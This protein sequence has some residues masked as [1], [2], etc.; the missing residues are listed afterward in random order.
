M[1]QAIVESYSR[2]K[3]LKLV[4][5]E[6]GMPF[7]SVYLVLRK[8]GVSV[9]GDKSRYGSETDRLAAGAEREFMSLV[10]D[11][12]NMNEVQFQSKIDFDVHGVTVDVKSSR[13]HQGTRM[14]LI[15]H[16]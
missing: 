16:F 6:V 1:Q 3:N 11:A 2:L 9:T 14:A 12:K 4:G 15:E 13:L 5:K 8:A 10:P 7:Q